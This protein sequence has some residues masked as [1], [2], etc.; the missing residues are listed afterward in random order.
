MMQ[1]IWS[2][3]W[4]PDNAYL[5]SYYLIILGNKASAEQKKFKCNKFNKVTLNFEISIP[6]VGKLKPSLVVYG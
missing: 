4:A 5:F 1:Q 2:H 3:S 6:N